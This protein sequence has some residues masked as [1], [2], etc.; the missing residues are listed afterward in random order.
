MYTSPVQRSGARRRP[1]SLVC[2]ANVFSPPPPY[3]GDLEPSPDEKGSPI[4]IPPP[5]PGIL[6]SGPS[7][8]RDSLIDNDVPDLNEDD[9]TPGN[10][11]TLRGV[12]KLIRQHEFETMTD[13]LRGRLLELTGSSP[14]SLSSPFDLDENDSPLRSSPYR[15]SPNGRRLRS[16]PSDPGLA[17]SQPRSRITSNTDARDL[18]LAAIRAEEDAATIAHLEA[19]LADA[20][21][22]EEAQRKAA[23]RLRRD[24]SRMKRELEHAEEAIIDSQRHTDLSSADRDRLLCAERVT[25]WASGYQS[26]ARGSYGPPPDDEPVVWGA[27]AFPEFLRYDGITNDTDTTV[28]VEPDSGDNVSATSDTPT[29]EATAEASATPTH[30][31]SSAS[32][33]SDEQSEA[34]TP[35]IGVAERAVRP[36]PLITA[37][38]F[39]TPSRDR[40]PSPQVAI[41]PTSQASSAQRTPV[42]AGQRGSLSVRAS[43]TGS[44]LLRESM[45]V[46]AR[47]FNSGVHPLPTPGHD[48]QISDADPTVEQNV[49]SPSA[50]SHSS[51]LSTVDSVCSIYSAVVGVHRSLGSELGSGF[52]PT[53]TRTN[54]DMAIW[55][56]PIGPVE[57]ITPLKMIQRGRHTRYPSNP[58]TMFRFRGTLESPSQ[59]SAYDNEHPE[60]AIRIGPVAGDWTQQ[61]SLTACP[62]PCDGLSE[63]DL[64]EELQVP[65]LLTPQRQP[66]R[67]GW[68]SQPGAGSNLTP[69]SG[70]TTGLAPRP[71]P[72][73]EYS[74]GLTPSPRNR[75]LRPLLLLS[76]PAMHGRTS[77]LALAKDRSAGR[78]G[79]KFSRVP[80]QPVPQPTPSNIVVAYTDCAKQGALMAQAPAVRLPVTIPGRI[81]H[82]V[83]CLI[84]VFLNYLEW[85]IILLYRFTVDIRAGPAGAEAALG[86]KPR[87]HPKRFYL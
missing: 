54:E 48:H 29:E 62:P 30:P 34:P 12:Q 3:A 58:T 24:L 61:S 45:R 83:V 14:T 46:R 19:A 78:A 56:M 53:P 37:S 77:S 76:R 28:S 18:R 80:P 10:T 52:H 43:G 23:A 16:V 60:A 73:D 36:R 25:Q 15:L 75:K 55:P 31:S 6:E 7:S 22:G 40:V 42:R 67:P 84:L 59:P 74:D 1:L 86:F 79:F 87:E 49:P 50:T 32:P 27:T 39:A 4:A 65:Q 13:T 63:M 5:P 2:E 9:C 81:T 51:D 41:I 72:W 68:P 38:T 8:V 33:S 66:A 71:D 47:S 70:F 82:D 35:L 17:F 64:T 69:S 44:N 20:R 21:D 57:P 26:R 11:L 85:F